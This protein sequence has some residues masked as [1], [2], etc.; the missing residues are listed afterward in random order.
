M[1][2]LDALDQKAMQVAG[3]LDSLNTATQSATQQKAEVEPAQS[4][5]GSSLQTLDSSA[6]Q[7]GTSLQST[8]SA[9]DQTAS[10][11]QGLDAAIASTANA[12]AAAGGAAQGAASSAPGVA[13]G[14]LIRGPGTSTSDSIAAWLSRGEF[15]VSAKAVEKYGTGTLHAL[16]QLRFPKFNIGGVVGLM[17]PRMP[18]IELPG[19]ADG[20][21]V[22]E[23]KPHTTVNVDLRTEHGTVRLIGSENV[24]AQLQKLAVTK[25]LTSTGRKPG[26]VGG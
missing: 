14:G 20:G 8:G 1:S 18:R 6:D 2:G 24:A 4:A 16:N 15:V 9:A 21:L 22:E 5:T 26:F 17:N 25:R 3:S 11:L 7:T 23:A 10:S 13:T 12:F 19:F